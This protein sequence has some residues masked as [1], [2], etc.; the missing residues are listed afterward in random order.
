MNDRKDVE[1]KFVC[2]HSWETL[3]PTSS[4]DNEKEVRFCTDC[5]K[6]VYW[7]SS[8]SEITSHG[9]QGHCVAFN[10]ARGVDPS[11]PPD[12][13]FPVTPPSEGLTSSEEVL[14]PLIESP[15]NAGDKRVFALS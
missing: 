15:R 8:E 14:E 7:C 13:K 10:F 6:E 3:E 2:P 11:C 1:M 4:D 5:S 9:M 12:D